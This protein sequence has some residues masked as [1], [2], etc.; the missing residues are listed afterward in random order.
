MNQNF[1]SILQAQIFSRVAYAYWYEGQEEL[2]A[3]NNG[4]GSTRK[5]SERAGQHWSLIDI[6]TD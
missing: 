1:A 2:G 5:Q 3:T 6:I 4:Y